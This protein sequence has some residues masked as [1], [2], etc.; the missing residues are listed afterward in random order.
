[1]QVMMMGL[2]RLQLFVGLSVKHE[3]SNCFC[4]GGLETV[5]L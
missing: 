2:L 5:C 4:H 3:P 1:M